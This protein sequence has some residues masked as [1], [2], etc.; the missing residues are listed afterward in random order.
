MQLSL[1][2]TF[3][4]VCNTS[5]KNINIFGHFASQEVHACSYDL[6]LICIQDNDN[7]VEP[8]LT[9]PPRSGQP[10]DS[11]QTLRHRLILA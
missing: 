7:T 4:L 8:L 10:P 6:V 3:M 11:G 5:F 1:L 9:D 2:L